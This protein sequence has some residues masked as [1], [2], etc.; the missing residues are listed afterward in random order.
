MKQ[1]FVTLYGKVVIERD[2]VYIRSLELPF[3]KT[4]F[5]VISYNMLWVLI[6]L[7]QFFRDD[8][9]RKY[10]GILMFGF[11]LLFRIPEIYDALIKRSYASRIPLNRVKTVNTEE[12]EHIGLNV[13]VVLHFKI[14]RYKKIVFRKL[15]QQYQPFVEAVSQYITQPQFA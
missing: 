2:V 11:L 6:F 4:A 12:E 15:E 5:A 3:S 8:E 7:M 14:G 1:E 9:P 13:T 10:I